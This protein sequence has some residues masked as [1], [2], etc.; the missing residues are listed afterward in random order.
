LL[1]ISIQDT[2]LTDNKLTSKVVVKKELRKYIDKSEYFAIYDAPIK[3]DESILNIPLLA[4]VLPLAWLTSSDIEVDQL[5]QGFKEAMDRL[6]IEFSKIY[7]SIPFTTEIK[8]DKL[9]K[10]RINVPDPNEST[11]LLFSGGADS[12]YSLITNLDLNPKPI[13]IWG[14]DGYPYPKY[15][16]YWNKV[17]STY[18]DF[19]DKHGLELHIIKSNPLSILHNRRIEHDFHK[20]LLD[21]TLWGRLQHS[22]VLLP[23]VAPLSIG[24]FNKLLIASSTHPDFPYSV[25]P[26]GSQ[27]II[28]EKI[29]WSSLKVIHDGYITKNEKILSAIREFYK[30]NELILRVCMKRKKAPDYFNCSDC[31]KCYRT[32]LPML[33]AGIDL[34]KCGFSLNNSKLEE[35]KSFIREEKFTPLDLDL[36]IDIQNLVQGTR[37]DSPKL[38]EFFNWFKDY[39]FQQENV[40]KYR[41]IYYKL[42]FSIAKILDEIYKKIGIHI[43]DPSPVQQ[44]HKEIS[45]EKEEAITHYPMEQQPEIKTQSVDIE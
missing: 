22:L 19:F 13:M 27:P 35:M 33:L 12:T 10:N 11:G 7:P 3:H 14:V 18:S 36:W 1:D 31:E 40:H 39:Q 9:V 21:G 24:R 25:F 41:Q 44:D 34:E 16:K 26:W 42:P 30:E 6:Q 2:K 37:F 23:I 28:D 4:T 38:N 15:L 20:L 8:A 45:Y 32:M 43:H 17:I 29:Q 5:D